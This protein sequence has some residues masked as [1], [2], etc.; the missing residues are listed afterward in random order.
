MTVRRASNVDGSVG[1]G[2][3]LVPMVLVV[4]PV[5]AKFLPDRVVDAE[6]SERDFL[7]DRSAGI[8]EM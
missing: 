6:I 8:A 1:F 4:A 5:V 3:D 2:F 7:D